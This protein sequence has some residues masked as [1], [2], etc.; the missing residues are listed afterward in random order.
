[1]SLAHSLAALR[2][3]QFFLSFF[4][5]VNNCRF[6]SP[7]R[8]IFTRKKVIHFQSARL[9]K[10]ER[11]NIRGAVM[12]R[13]QKKMAAVFIFGGGRGGLTNQTTSRVIICG[14]HAPMASEG[15]RT[16]FVPF[17]FLKKK[18]YKT[19]WCRSD[20]LIYDVAA[21]G[22]FGC[23][24][25]IRRELTTGLCS[26]RH[27]ARDD[28]IQNYYYY[29]G[30]LSIW[31]VTRLFLLSPSSPPTT[32]YDFFFLVSRTSSSN[33]IKIEGETDMRRDWIRRLLN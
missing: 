31:N 8:G 1:M 12:R 5:T 22:P 4:K 16:S 2:R 28:G 26:S 3:I 7:S 11:G 19:S 18:T 6:S 33:T 29:L 24:F 25:L 15:R 14:A 9:V 27:S 21:A 17:F 13:P 32:F 10:K 20:F 23:Y 30:F